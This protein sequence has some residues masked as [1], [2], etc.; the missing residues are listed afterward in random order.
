MIRGKLGK[1]SL[2]ML[3]AFEGS[4][5]DCAVWLLGELNWST[6]VVA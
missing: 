2:F 1:L 5:R 3:F 4:R 6:I